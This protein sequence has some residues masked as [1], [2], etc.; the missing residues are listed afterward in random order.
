M[1]Q[2]DVDTVQY[3]LS[4]S[5]SA[6]TYVNTELKQITGKSLSSTVI[7]Q[8][9]S[10][11]DITYDPLTSA[12]QTAA[13]HAYALGFLKSSPDLN[14]IYYLGPLNQVLTSK[15]LAAVAGS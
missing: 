3:I 4:N 13:E 7:A 8:S 10:N 11:L 2:A 1:T 15:G 14:G 6:Q 5:T 9:F 12:V